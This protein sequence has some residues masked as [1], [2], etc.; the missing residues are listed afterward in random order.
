MPDPQTV[1]EAQNYSGW[2]GHILTSVLMLLAGAAGWGRLKKSDE[3]QDKT[4]KSQQEEI[5]KIKESYDAKFQ[6]IENK[7]DQEIKEIEAKFLDHDGIGLFVTWHAFGEKC[8]DKQRPMMIQLEH[9]NQSLAVVVGSLVTINGKLD[10]CL[11]QNAELFGA[12][13]A[14]KEMRKKGEAA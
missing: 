12:Y 3:D 5:T 6:L 13:E 7:L 9:T 11:Q 4:L 2:A 1:Q 14:E 10:A 8:A